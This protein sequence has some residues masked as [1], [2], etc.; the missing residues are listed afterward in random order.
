MNLLRKFMSEQKNRIS[1]VTIN[2]D[3]CVHIDARIDDAL[4]KKLLPEI[5]ALRQESNNPI[6]VAINSP[7]GSVAAAETIL[8]LIT[9]PHQDKTTCKA[10]TVSVHRAYSAA[11]TLLASGDYSV[12]LQNSD[13]LFHDVRY[14]GMEDVTPTVARA[15][16]AQLQDANDELA[17]K[18]A[19]R[20][21]RRLVW[22][23]ID[24][25]GNFNELREKFPTR[26]EHYAQ[27]IATCGKGAI[28]AKVDIASF[29]TALY[30]NLSRSSDSFIDKTMERLHRWALMTSISAAAP[31]YRVKGTR[32]P[33]LLDGSRS[34]FEKMRRLLD[35]KE[36][37]LVWE[38]IAPDLKLFLTLLIENT[39]KEKLARSV[40]FSK[41]LETATEDYKLIDSINDPAHFRAAT[42]QLL[43]HK[44]IFFSNE[45]LASLESGDEQLREA[46]FKEAIPTAKLFWH[47]C[48]LLCTELF[49]G[50]HILTPSD[51]QLL[52][53]VDEVG[54]GGPIESRREFREKQA[55]EQTK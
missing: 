27:I 19:N 10:I 17:L 8:A 11:A 44:S 42:K 13:I 36:G 3:R 47:F 14:G 53:L 9:G 12:A 30:A 40:D 20:I 21:F 16:A 50:E 24:L 23:Y 45:A 52:G 5:L 15:A 54:G 35:Y 4:I 26:H 32:T 6:T 2:W 34:L 28:A 39:A 55:A 43:R 22:N 25:R 33:G 41:M 29:A 37:D 51:A 1:E 31:D 48:V 46:A 7:G 18:L 49:N 38:K